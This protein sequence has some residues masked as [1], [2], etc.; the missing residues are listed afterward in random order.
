MED[1]TM[2]PNEHRPIR[3]AATLLLVVAATL[4]AA[5]LPATAAGGELWLRVDV[6]RQGEEAGRIK[7]NVPLSLMEVVIESA[8]GQK[9]FGPLEVAQGHVDI[10]RMWQSIRDMANEEI[11]SIEA[12]DEIIKVWKDR[13]YFRVDV[14]K[15][16]EGAEVEVKIPLG[17]MDYLFNSERT[18]FDFKELVGAMRGYAPIQ[19]VKVVSNEE[20]VSI[21]IEER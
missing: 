6:T 21:W 8:D 2:T 3:S 17:L 14:K 18:G 13:D 19:L 16:D 7:I 15:A 5:Q 1:P 11:L 12:E 10:G 4:L 9:F 20:N